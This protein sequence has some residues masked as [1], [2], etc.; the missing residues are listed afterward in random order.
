[1]TEQQ[2]DKELLCEI[3]KQ[4][5]KWSHDSR[6]AGYHHEIMNFVADKIFTHLLAD[7]KSTV[8]IS[9]LKSALNSSNNILRDIT[10]RVLK[11]KAKPTGRYSKMHHRHSRR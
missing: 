8:I 6:T 10:D 5:K 9:G 4:L 3:A 7:K 2:T 11:E 1:M